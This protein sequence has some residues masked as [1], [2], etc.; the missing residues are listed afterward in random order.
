MTNGFSQRNGRRDL[1]IAIVGAGM[2]GIL[3]A[4][5]LLEDGYRDIVIYEKAAKLGGT[6]R[7]NRYPGLSCDIPSHVYSY[8][9]APNPDWSHKYSPGPEIQAYFEGVAQDFDVVKLMRFSTEVT[10]AVYDAGTWQ[11]WS[12]AQPLGTV[13]VVLAATGILHHPHLPDFEGLESF[14]GQTFHSARWPENY[15]LAGKRVAL[16]GTGST[17]IQIVNAVASEVEQLHL[18]QRTA[19]WIW[20]E[21]N[22]P[23]SEDD[24]ARFRDD[25]STLEHIRRRMSEIIDGRFSN[26]LVA[27]DSEAMHRIEAECRSHLERHVTDPELKAKLTPDYR[28]GCKRLIMATGFYENMTRPNVALVT[29]PIERI[30]PRG[31]RTE[32]G[33]LHEAETLVLAT[34]FDAH[35]FM[36]P[37][38]VL[39]QDGVR[40]DDVWSDEI[41]AYRSISV[42]GFPNFFMLMGPQ[43]PVG[44]FS[45]IDVADIQ[46]HYI[47]QLLAQ[48]RKGW[49]AIAPNAEA[50]RRFTDKV[51]A[52][53]RS[54][55]WVTGCRS[56][57]LDDRGVPITWPW[58]VQD[59]A[60]SMK[61]VALEDY[62]LS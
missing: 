61:T 17:A 59:F 57:Y 27:A 15:S 40:L 46:Y 8:P 52:G 62:E 2:S 10:Q 16:V 18:F 14:E 49:R 34:G 25:P 31:V 43:S 23:Y 36:R 4:I 13:D 45:L 24:R 35:Q 30:E 47:A 6:W 9:F 32:N 55:I 48:L 5:R 50:T 41:F 12:N 28:A 37:M 11:L 60:D 3:C 51:I 7:E 22:S 26:A 19:Q 44:N 1:R 54:T 56:W 21:P 20:P 58:T 38:Q 53:M 33:T 42:P 29:E 39:G